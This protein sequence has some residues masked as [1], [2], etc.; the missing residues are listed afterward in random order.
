MPLRLKR[1]YD[2]SADVDGYRVL[3]DRLWPR[4]VSKEDARLDDWLK[5]L[6]PSDELRRWFDHD[7]DKWDEFKRRYFDELDQNEAASALLQR[8]EDNEAIT[9]LYAAKDEKHNN[10]VALREWLMQDTQ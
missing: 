2:E 7:P 9:L 8:L 6:A 1:I 5:E 3:V 4:G 10:A